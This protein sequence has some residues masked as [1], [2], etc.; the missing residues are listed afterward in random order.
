MVGEVAPHNQIGAASGGF[1]CYT[2]VRHIGSVLDELS[3]Q[4]LEL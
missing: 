3:Y 4:G 2:L 1:V